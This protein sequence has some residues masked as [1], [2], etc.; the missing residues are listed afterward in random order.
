[1]GIDIAKVEIE[2]LPRPA[3]LA[4]EFIRELACGCPCIGEGNALGWFERSEMEAKAKEFAK[5]NAL[6]EAILMDWIASLPW[7]EDNCLTLHFNW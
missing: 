7:D 6:A 2:H 4:Y 3:G 1:V 5:G